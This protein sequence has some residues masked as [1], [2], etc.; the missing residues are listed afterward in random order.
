M[1]LHPP[2]I[3]DVRGLIRSVADRWR[4]I[5][6]EKMRKLWWSITRSR[7]AW[8]SS[9]QSLILVEDLSKNI[10]NGF[11]TQVL[12]LNTTQSRHTVPP[13]PDTPSSSTIMLLCL[14]YTCSCCWWEQLCWSLNV[15]DWATCYS[16]VRQLGGISLAPTVLQKGT[17]KQFYLMTNG[18]EGSRQCSGQTCLTYPLFIWISLTC[19]GIKVYVKCWICYAVILCS[20]DKNGFLKVMHTHFC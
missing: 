2:K 20:G 6:P 13:L 16:S 15:V 19:C 11:F 4:R 10:C 9:C 1:I 18:E 12:V 14:R 7:R 3:A 8:F 5:D 17:L